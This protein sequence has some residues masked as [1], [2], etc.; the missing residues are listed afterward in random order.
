[1]VLAATVKNAQFF[2][3]F[4][5]NICRD[6][7]KRLR[8]GLYRKVVFTL[9]HLK[10]GENGSSRKYQAGFRRVMDEEFE[11]VVESKPLPDGEERLRRVFDLLLTNGDEEAYLVESYQADLEADDT[12]PVATAAKMGLYKTANLYYNKYGNKTNRVKKGRN[13]QNVLR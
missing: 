2:G 12:P 9:R 13:E 11:V 5:L 7:E 8:P 6:A 1:L 3:R 4:Q 10:N